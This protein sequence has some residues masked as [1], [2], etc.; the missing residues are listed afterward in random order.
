MFF[1]CGQFLKIVKEE[2]WPTVYLLRG[3]QCL[4]MHL[5][6]DANYSV[7]SSTPAKPWYSILGKWNFAR[8]S[9]CLAT[10]IGLYSH[11]LCSQKSLAFRVM[12]WA[13]IF[14]KLLL[15][16]L[17][18]SLSRGGIWQ[19]QDGGAGCHWRAERRRSEVSFASSICISSMFSGFRCSFFLWKLL[20]T[21][22]ATKICLQMM[23][24][25][26]LSFPF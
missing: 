16:L 10:R 23:K 15:S 18:F 26:S 24:C 25:K 8:Q 6:M 4:K 3:V 17:F 11:L 22:L 1:L 2:C 19:V 9:V 14:K 21:S 12:S 13:H 5:L 7:H 20:P